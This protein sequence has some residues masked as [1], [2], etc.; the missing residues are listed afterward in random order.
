MNFY[1]YRNK[2]APWKKYAPFLQD[3]TMTWSDVDD[4]NPAFAAQNM[5]TIDQYI[6]RSASK[7]ESAAE[8]LTLEPVEVR[9]GSSF[10]EKEVVGWINDNIVGFPK[11]EHKRKQLFLWGASNLG[12]SY[13]ATELLPKFA[14]VY[15]GRNQWWPDYSDDRYDVIV[16]N[17]FS[18]M[19]PLTTL[20]LLAEGS[21]VHIEAKNSSSWKRKNLPMI[22]CS[23]RPFGEIYINKDLQ[24]IEAL[25]NRFLVLNLHSVM[26]LVLKAKDSDVTSSIS[27]SE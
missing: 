8:L 12:K 25:E 22:I 2:Q 14:R 4:E 27:Q 11:R 18:G 3:G 26:H 24:T 6:Q 17:E 10:E 21:Q 13:W 23:N 7:R 19:I 9:Q 16:F 1:R 5:R 15:H 20:N